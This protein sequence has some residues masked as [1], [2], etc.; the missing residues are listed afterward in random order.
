MESSLSEITAGKCNYTSETPLPEGHNASA[1]C[2]HLDPSHLP[3]RRENFEDLSRDVNLTPGANAQ[4]AFKS[5]VGRVI[6]IV[7]EVKRSRKSIKVWTV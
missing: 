4:I 2:I 3:N 6:L 1:T 5:S 7:I